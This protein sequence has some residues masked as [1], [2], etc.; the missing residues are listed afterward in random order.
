VLPARSL[1]AT[2]EPWLAG[3]DESRAQELASAW[4]DGRVRAVF[5]ARGGFGS[6][7]VL[8]LVDWRA[9]A[10]QGP[11]WLVGYSDVTAVHQAF[12]ARLGV[13]TVHGPVVAGLPTMDP[14]AV[15]ALR[16]LLFDGEVPTLSGTPGGGGEAHGPL[17]GGNLA[18]LAASAG[19]AGVHPARDSVALL[20]DIAE[21]PYRLDRLLTQLLRSGWFEGVRAVALGQFTDC[22]DPEEVRRLLRSRLGPLGVPLVLDLPIGHIDD[23][24]SVVLG[25]RVTLDGD[26]GTLA[27]NDPM[28]A[29]GSAPQRVAGRSGGPV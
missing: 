28:A 24:R 21:E 13:A 14:S 9:M 6:Q 11:A 29:A 2:D 18:V 20:E 12:A 4:V 8:D 16:T 27:M 22:G 23:S 15:E 1:P 10:Q 7:R 25:R 5:A 26:A 3:T 17:V 19:T